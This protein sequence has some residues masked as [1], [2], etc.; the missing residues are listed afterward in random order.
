[1]AGGKY[2]TYRLMSEQIVDRVLKNWP[3]ERRLSYGRCSTNQPLNKQVGREQLETAVAGAITENELLLCR[4][5]GS[6]GHEILKNYGASCSY[7]ELEACHAIYSNMCLGLVDFYTRRVPLMLSYQDHGLSF[8]P[9]I[10]EV[11]RRELKW[12]K[13]ELEGQQAQLKLYIETE[14]AWKKQ[15][16]KI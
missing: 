10:A 7:W 1:M 15:F 2:T 9:L 8:L 4:R 14:L 11:F 16:S 6:E 3:V 5:F 13:N 12:T